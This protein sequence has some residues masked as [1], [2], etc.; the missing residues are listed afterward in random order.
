MPFRGKARGIE[1]PGPPHRRDADLSSNLMSEHLHPDSHGLKHKAGMIQPACSPPR[2]S[3]QPAL[4]S[5]S[6]SSARR[7][8][9]P[10]QSAT[11]PVHTRCY[12]HAIVGHPLHHAGDRYLELRLLHPWV[13][14]A[15]PAWACESVFG[16]L[17]EVATFVGSDVHLHMIDGALVLCPMAAQPPPD[18]QERDWHLQNP[19]QSSDGFT[20]FPEEPQD[21]PEEATADP[22]IDPMLDIAARLTK[23]SSEQ[24]RPALF[25]LQ[26]P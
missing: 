8:R 23:I 19:W 1:L 25:W 12:L 9:L 3:S 17:T 10:H 26:L 20:F 21:E 6:R 13:D 15:L 16:D 7:P 2:Q 18:G 11:S 24:S 14:C 22:G 4:S 5:R